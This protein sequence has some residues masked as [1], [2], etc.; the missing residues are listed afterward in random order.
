MFV[1]DAPMV[2]VVERLSCNP[3]S[4]LPGGTITLTAENV[5]DPDGQVARVVFYRDANGNG[6]LEPGIDT[7]LGVDDDGTNG[8]TWTGPTAGWPDGR[9]VFMVRVRDNQGLW[10]EV[11]LIIRE[12]HPVNRGCLNSTL[13]LLIC[14]NVLVRRGLCLR[15]TGGGNRHVR[16]T[17]VGKK[18]SASKMDPPQ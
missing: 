7:V 9:I 18:K 11:K 13:C 17:H 5:F 10:S 4:I 15:Q 2:P 1:T 16:G 8:W 12:I 14:V 6:T 3:T